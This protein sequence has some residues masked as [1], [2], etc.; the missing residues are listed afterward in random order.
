MKCVP[1]K[2]I[3]GTSITIS[4]TYGTHQINEG[5]VFFSYYLFLFEKSQVINHTGEVEIVFQ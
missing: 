1:F 5:R 3:D 4:S 2:Y